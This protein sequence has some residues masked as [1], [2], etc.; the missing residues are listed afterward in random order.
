MAPSSRGS[1]GGADFGLRD[2]RLHVGVFDEKAEGIHE[3]HLLGG[4]APYSEEFGAADEHGEGPGSGDGDVEA[5]QAE[6]ELEVA[7]HVVGRGSSHG[8]DDDGGLLTLELVRGSDPRAP[9]AVQST[10]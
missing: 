10:Q 6:E 2:D 7:G 4:P 9:L 3:A 8:E 5:I 1:C